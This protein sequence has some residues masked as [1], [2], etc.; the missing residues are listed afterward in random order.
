MNGSKFFDFFGKLE[1]VEPD[2]LT[3]DAGERFVFTLNYIYF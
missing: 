2:I 3:G 1:A